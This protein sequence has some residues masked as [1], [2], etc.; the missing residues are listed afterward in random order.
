MNM[1]NILLMLLLTTV[2]GAGVGVYFYGPIGALVGAGTAV[3][4]IVCFLIFVFS[5]AD[6]G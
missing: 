6:I 2:F 3:I 5:Q 4:L 1:K